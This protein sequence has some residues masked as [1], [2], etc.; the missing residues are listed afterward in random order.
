MSALLEEAIRC[1][2]SCLLAPDKHR[3]KL[4]HEAE[5]WLM[6]DDTNA[7]VSFPEVCELLGLDIGYIRKG[8]CRWRARETS[9]LLATTANRLSG[10]GPAELR[11]VD[12]ARIPPPCRPLR[13]IRSAAAR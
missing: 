1:F 7:L 4:F 9:V 10:T 8:L 2:Q 6:E 3:R 5:R 13:A 12:H 11:R